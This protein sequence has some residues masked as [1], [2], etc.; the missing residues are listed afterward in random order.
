MN[1][2]EYKNY[3]V[4]PTQEAFLIRPIRLLYQK[5]K[6]KFK[7][8][9]MQQLAVIYFM[10]DPRSSYNYIIDDEERLKEIIMQEGLPENYTIP[11]IVQEAIT[12]YKKHVVTTSYLLLEDTKHVIANMR[13]AL[14]S[15]DFSEDLDVK[16][17]ATAIKTVASITSMIPKIVKDLTE[18]ER[19]INKEITENTRIKGGSDSATLFDG[20]FTDAV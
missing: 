7:E 17:K 13:Q 12:E 11:K 15:I 8:V 16:D 6:S 5:D 4:I 18:A 1:V 9:F 2:L 20:G 19:S 3:E 10:A 14:R